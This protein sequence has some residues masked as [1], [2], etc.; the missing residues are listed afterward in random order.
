MPNSATVIENQIFIGVPWK[1]IRPK[2]ETVL[3]DLKDEYPVHWVIFGRTTTHDA[4]DLWDSIKTEI[5]RSAGTI[6]DLT[7]SNANVALEFGYAEALGK[8]RV[9]TKH[10]ASTRN[11]KKKATK[12]S[13]PDSIMS[14]LAGKI[15]APY[16]S[17]VALKK[18]LKQE[19][20]RNPYVVRFKQV[21][22]TK[23]WGLRKKRVAI[24]IT[25][26]LSGGKKLSRPNLTLAIEAEFS[27]YKAFDFK[28]LLDEMNEGKL[29][30]I[31]RGMHGGVT[32]PMID[33]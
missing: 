18:T 31:K 27:T 25:Q 2:F 24:A 3:S 20:D 33:S 14:D 10:E 29:I 19:F 22:K 1:T 8:R 32:M 5:D 15:R 21:A 11:S 16:K 6:F 4:Q 9:L 28:A 7:G 30:V 13:V 26:H 23:K 12:K 17:T